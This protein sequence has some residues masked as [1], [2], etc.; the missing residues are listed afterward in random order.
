MDEVT[1]QPR[2]DFHRVTEDT[3][4][5]VP[6]QTWAP[7]TSKGAIDAIYEAEWALNLSWCITRLFQ[8]HSMMV[9]YKRC[10]YLR[11]RRFDLRGDAVKI[12][13][14]LSSQLATTIGI[15]FNKLN[16]F[17][18]LQDLAGNWSR[19]TAEVGRP[20]SIVLV[21][22]V[23]KIGE[24]LF[25]CP[26]AKPYL[27]RCAWQSWHQSG[28]GCKC[29]WPRRPYGWGTNPHQREPTPCIHQF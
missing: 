21:S 27:R 17:Q 2:R 10:N 6:R 16:S 25:N 4:Q 14:S 28:T 19:A 29:A 11:L 1:V 20:H 12:T 13:E 24:T 26:S 18:G 7:N 9:G 5:R 22:Y 15:L 23:K 3:R 8:G